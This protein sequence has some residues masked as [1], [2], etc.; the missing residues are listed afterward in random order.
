MIFSKLEYFE[1]KAACRDFWCVRANEHHFNRIRQGGLQKDSVVLGNYTTERPETNRTR[2]L[3]E[4][5][6]KTLSKADLNDAE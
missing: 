3:S 4:E 2:L 6:S 5:L 1:L